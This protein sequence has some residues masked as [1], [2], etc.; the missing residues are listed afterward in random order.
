MRN[1]TCSMAPRSDPAGAVDAA[2]D[3]VEGDPHADNRAPVPAA[4]A[5]PRKS[6]RSTPDRFPSP[7]FLPALVST[8]PLCYPEQRTERSPVVK[9]DRKVNG[10]QTL[11]LDQAFPPP[12]FRLMT[13]GLVY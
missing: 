8:V 13:N 7:Y 2:L 4:N 5:P 12:G 11:G 3:T 9:R 6:R 1:T 10:M